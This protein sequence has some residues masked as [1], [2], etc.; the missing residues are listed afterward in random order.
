MNKDLEAVSIAIGKA[1]LNHVDKPF[2]YACFKLARAALK[3]DPVRREVMQR[4]KIM[5]DA[6]DPSVTW[7]AKL[8]ARLKAQTEETEMQHDD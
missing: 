3:A 5:A 8:L 2:S 1:S 4:L 6:E 7:P